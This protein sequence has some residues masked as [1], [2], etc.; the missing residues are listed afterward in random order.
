MA[1]KWRLYLAGKWGVDQA[2]VGDT[3]RIVCR[4]LDGRPIPGTKVVITPGARCAEFMRNSVEV[5]NGHGS[6]TCPF[7]DAT[8]KLDEVNIQRLVEEGFGSYAERS[9]P[10]PGD[11]VCCNKQGGS[12]GHITMY[13]GMQDTPVGRIECVWEN[14]S[15]DERGWPR[16]PGTKMSPLS[17]VR[18]EISGIYQ[19]F[20]GDIPGD[21]PV[22]Y[23]PGDCRIA[24][25][26]WR[27][28]VPGWFSDHAD[29]SIANLGAL[30]G[31][32]PE[33][34]MVGHRAVTMGDVLEVALPEPVPGYEGYAPGPMMLVTPLGQ[35]PGWFNGQ[36]ATVG[37]AAAAKILGYVAVDEMPTARRV[38]LT[39]RSDVPHM[40]GNGVLAG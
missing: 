4:K 14:T 23:A 28:T 17:A 29:V 38:V 2:L 9:A 11:I 13:A 6:G 40:V 33:D 21:I 7:A 35:C 8:A 10:E 22:G 18:G 20:P 16:R 31:T 19:V 36:Y 3:G 26:G 24:L 25:K 30:I 27:E 39:P 5:A 1:T 34:Q 32:P 12:W 37:A 15:S